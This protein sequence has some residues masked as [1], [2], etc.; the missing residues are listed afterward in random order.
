MLTIS[1]HTAI[2]HLVAT[3][4]IHPDTNKSN[5]PQNYFLGVNVFMCICLYNVFTSY[6]SRYPPPGKTAFLGENLGPEHW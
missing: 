5:V 6:S 2:R 4:Y 1:P 3:L